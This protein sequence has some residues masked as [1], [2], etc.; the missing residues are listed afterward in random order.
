MITATMTGNFGNHMWNYVLCRLVAEKLGY[1]WG[2]SP[3]AT[4]DYHNGASQLYFLDIDYGK[5]VTKIGTNS[6]TLNVY[7]GIDNL[8]FSF[9]VK[10]PIYFK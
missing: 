4:H 5:E 7:E 2:V 9:R 3:I 8:V 1:E 10:K 6:K